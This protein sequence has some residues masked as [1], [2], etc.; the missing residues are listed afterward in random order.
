MNTDSP[1]RK[2]MRQPFPQCQ[3]PIGGAAFT[4]IELLVVIAII[5][6]LAAMLLP[7]LSK[8]K[9]KANA[10]ACLNNLKQVGL[11]M[12][13]YTDENRDIFPVHRDGLGLFNASDWWGPQIVTY[14]G[15]MSNLFQCPAIKGPQPLAG[16]AQTWTWIFDRDK[17]GY[18]Y[19]S[20]FLGLDYYAHANPTTEPVGG[21]TFTGTRAF[22]RTSVRKPT[23][24]LMICDSEPESSGFWSSS[25]WWPYAG[26]QGNANYSG[27]SMSRHS[28]RGNV[29][30][31]DGHSESRKDGQINPPVNPHGAGAQGLINSKYWDPLQT[32]GDK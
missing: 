2:E 31:V 12:Q 5:A 20:M 32:A 16:T 10:I 14:G 17:V 27:V 9:A 22:K 29:G 21:I 3:R 19:N 7:A 26:E 13:L 4:L 30:F 24:N 6:I 28:Q 11:F 23:D 25:R 15:G 8:A 18:G 1:N